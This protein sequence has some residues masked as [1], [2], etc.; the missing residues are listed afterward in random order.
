MMVVYIQYAEKSS[1]RKNRIAARRGD[2]H[3][4]ATNRIRFVAL[5]QGPA[6]GGHPKLPLE[7][8]SL[9]LYPRPHRWLG[10]DHSGRPQTY[11]EALV[12]PLFPKY[13]G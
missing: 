5:M 13:K 6:V 4:S 1:M 7:D 2:A 10:G 11:E 9:T 8:R 12:H 3:R